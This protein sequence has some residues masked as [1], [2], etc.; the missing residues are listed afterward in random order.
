M[1][2]SGPAQSSIASDPKHA[3]HETRGGLLLTFFVSNPNIELA[4]CLSSHDV[5]KSIKLLGLSLEDKFKRKL[6]TDGFF[7]FVFKLLDRWMARR[8]CGDKG[9]SRQINK[10]FANG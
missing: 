5:H 2:G 4:R 1:A 8:S 6:L 3:C 9:I 7:L 10:A